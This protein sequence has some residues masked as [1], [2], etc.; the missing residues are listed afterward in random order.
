[1]PNSS[2]RR[3][4]VAGGGV[5]GLT[6][7]FA[8]RQAGFDVLV[9]EQEPEVRGIGAALGLWANALE[10]FDR[11]G[12]GAA[13][14]AAGHPSAIRYQDPTGQVLDEYYADLAGVNYLMVTRQRLNELLAE[15]VGPD[16][17]RTSARVVGYE[18]RASAVTVR[19][20]DGSTTEA[21]LLIGADGVYSKVREQLSPGS[22][23][24]EYPGHL[25]WRGIVP[26]SAI[27]EIT[28]ER[29]VVG[30]ER[31]RGGVVR[32][33]GGLAFW[34]LAQLGAQSSA[35]SGKQEALALVPYLHEG[36]WTFPLREAI[37]ATPEDK[38]VRNRVMAVPLQ[39]RWVDGHVAL[40]GDAAHALSPHI[41]SGA[42]L[43][44][45]DAAVLADH[46]GRSGDVP[47]ALKA[48]EADRLP[49]YAE[50]YRRVDEVAEASVEP[51]EF[52]K[53]FFGFIRWMLG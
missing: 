16:H 49:R 36:D 20:E 28:S 21:D 39:T 23:A 8:L 38:V 9:C 24:Q 11:L 52:A 3:A 2:E 53:E 31:T 41:T 40:A 14:R 48:Y 44:I 34:V 51:R 1:M 32:S 19:F 45:E 37:E 7:G 5:V 30:R 47:A 29:F 13:I 46:L 35:A 50:A 15:A 33:G 12:V 4:V 22:A 43:G 25:A 27:P 10:V 42:S 26:E 6:T 18:D 17:L